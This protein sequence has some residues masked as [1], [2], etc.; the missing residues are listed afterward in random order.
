MQMCDRSKRKEQE[1]RGKTSEYQ[2]KRWNKAVGLLKD[3]SQPAIWHLENGL[4]CEFDFLALD[5]DRFSA[6]SPQ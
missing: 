5:F 3:T 6:H 1:G 4:V 2:R